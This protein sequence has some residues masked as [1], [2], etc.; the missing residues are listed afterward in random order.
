M[1]GR[2]GE[3]VCEREKRREREF[4]CVREREGGKRRLVAN[5]DK[6]SLNF[7]HPILI[8]TITLPVQHPPT[9]RVG[10]FTGWQKN[11]VQFHVF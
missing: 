10:P 11:P 6:S 4:V 7:P 9:Y 2:M 1:R 8:L 3:S 5:S